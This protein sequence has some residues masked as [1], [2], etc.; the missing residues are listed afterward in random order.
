MKTNLLM[1]IAAHRDDFSKGQR[2]IARFISEQYDEAAYM[3]AF[4][5]GEAVG[6]SEST[7]VRFAA[8]IGFD[9]YPELQKAVQELVRSRL[10]TLKRIELTRE[11][12]TDDEVLDNVLTSDMNNVRLTLEALPQEIFNAAVHDIVTARRVYIFGAGSC[13]PLAGFAHYYFKLLMQ[14]TCLLSSGSI[15]EIFEEMVD[16]GQEKCL[17]TNKSD[18]LKILK[19]LYGSDFE[20]QTFL[21]RTS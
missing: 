2:A 7:V 1:R 21:D 6:V 4:Q 14:N 8:E 10:T 3:T 5:L 12:M 15:A 13:R 9:G 17:G 20:A 18:T 16:I 19:S 11:R